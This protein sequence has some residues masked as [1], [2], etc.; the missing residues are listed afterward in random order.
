[1]EMDFEPSEEGLG[2]LLEAPEVIPPAMASQL[3]FA[4]APQPLNEIE[5]MRLSCG[6]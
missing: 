4:I 6:V 5:L 3:A 2:R 1:M